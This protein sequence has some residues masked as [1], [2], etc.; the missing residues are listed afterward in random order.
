VTAA[1]VLRAL[2][3]DPRV[4]L[5]A[6]AFANAVAI[7]AVALLPGDPYYGEGGLGAVIIE[8]AVFIGLL[9]GSKLAW[10]FAVFGS[11][12]AAGFVVVGAVEPDTGPKFLLVGGLGL[13]AVLLLLS[14]AMDARVWNRPH[15]AE[16]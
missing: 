1:S 16:R 10:G 13:L 9:R 12:M 14:P 8:G 2:W 4:V 15:A 11:V 5:W 7:A 3:R 6:Y